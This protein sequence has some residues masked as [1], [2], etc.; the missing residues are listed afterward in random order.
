MRSARQVIVDRFGGPD[1][2][3]VIDVSIASPRSEQIL[4]RV[5]AAG[6]LYGD[7]M[8][9]TNHYLT[10]TPLPYAPGTE[11]AGTVVEIGDKVSVLKIGERVFCRVGS[12]GYAQYALAEA[13][14]AIPLP[15]GIG[16]AEA[17]ALLAQGTTAYLLTHEVATLKDKF[18]FIESVAG[19]VGMQMAQ[20]AKSAGAAFVAGSASS[21]D[22][23]EF[24]RRCGVDLIVSSI[25]Q[26]WSAQVLEAT[27]RRGVDIAYESSGASFVELLKCLSPFGTIVKFGRGIN[28]HQS[29]DPSLLVGK[30]QTLRGFYLPGYFDPAHHLLLDAATH[31]LTA[32]VLSGELKLQISHRFPL[33]EVALAHRAIEERRT[34]GKVV[35]EPW[36]AKV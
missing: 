24:A 4:V 15:D 8:R 31:S 36:S 11:I 25:Q 5:E 12:Q 6:V 16:F 9:R 20:M 35:L 2:L 1:V 19:G 33:N 23:R 26:G 18:V 32:A 27:G 21:D 29:F 17:T 10:E 22:K 30:N 14:H 13:S 34:M 7:V 28:E 3:K